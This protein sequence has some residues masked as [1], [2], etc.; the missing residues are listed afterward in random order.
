MFGSLAARVA[1][2]PICWSGVRSASRDPREVRAN[3]DDH[4]RVW[5][6]IRGERA[7]RFERLENDV[8]RA[9]ALLRLGVS[10]FGSALYWASDLVDAAYLFE[11]S[12][13]RSAADCFAEGSLRK[14]IGMSLA[15]DR[16]LP[17]LPPMLIV[18]RQRMN[19]SVCL[20]PAAPSEGRHT[21]AI[22]A[23][24]GSGLLMSTISP[25]ALPGNP[26]KPGCGV[27]W[28]HYTIRPWLAEIAGWVGP[29][30]EVLKRMGPLEE[31]PHL[32]WLDP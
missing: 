21:T 16:T 29:N 1:A 26:F 32:E 23:Q 15:A 27:V 4:E 14:T 24:L 12:A 9:A 3:V 11:P 8:R 30:G 19:C 7:E 5:G 6:R 17:G 31:L 28:T 25:P 22:D 10:G 2:T 20:Q 13:W 18:D